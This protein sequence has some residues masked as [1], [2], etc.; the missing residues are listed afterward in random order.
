MA[1][2]HSSGVSSGIYRFPRFFAFLLRHL[3]LSPARRD[4]WCRPLPQSRV[5]SAISSAL[6]PL[7]L[8]TP[9]VS[10]PLLPP[11]LPPP[12]LPYQRLSPSLARSFRVC[13]SAF[14]S[15]PPQWHVPIHSF[16]RF[17][18]FHDTDQPLS[19]SVVP[20]F[21]FWSRPTSSPFTFGQAAI[22]KVTL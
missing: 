11:P 1:L 10:S 16:P 4:I 18:L 15:P 5:P 20:I 21:S 22:V 19:L 17:T 9:T 2:F 7:Q 8:Q 13:S 12:T 6:K 14:P 3:L